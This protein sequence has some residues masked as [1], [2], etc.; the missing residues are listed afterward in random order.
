MP[1]E[2]SPYSL[3]VNIISTIKPCVLTY[4]VFLQDVSSENGSEKGSRYS[5]RTRTTQNKNPAKTLGLAKRTRDEITTQVNA[6]KARRQAEDDAKASA[7]ARAA[8]ARAI[9]VAKLAAL[10]DEH[11]EQESTELE[12]FGEYLLVLFADARSAIEMTLT[13]SNTVADALGSGPKNQSTHTTTH[14]Q[15]P[16]EG[17]D[18]RGFELADMVVDEIEEVPTAPAKK[19]RAQPMVFFPVT[20]P[21][22]HAHSN[23]PI[24]SY[25]RLSSPRRRNAHYFATPLFLRSLPNA[26]PTILRPPLPSQGPGLLSAHRSWT[27][28]SESLAC[29]FPRRT[30][31]NTTYR[32]LTTHNSREKPTA[33]SKN[34]DTDDAFSLSWRKKIQ[35]THR[36]DTAS[37]PG[38][39]GHQP[40]SNEDEEEVIGGLQDE[41]VQADRDVV[42]NAGVS[43]ARAR[44]KQVRHS[45]DLW[46]FIALTLR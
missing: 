15:V 27:T 17:D 16:E 24:P 23:P 7:K 38:T 35:Q 21:R 32:N 31:W 25:P 41:D 37:V 30:H 45:N 6:K 39:P 40:S 13:P 18:A 9:K 46:A 44:A 34:T 1:V 10:E 33:S 36:R 14:L 42:I 22:T 12:M 26:S 20:P 2:G 11:L 4:M 3:E 43:G 5:L 8:E 28:A 19:V 29:P